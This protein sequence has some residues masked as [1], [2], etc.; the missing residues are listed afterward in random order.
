MTGK[1]LSPS[2]LLTNASLVF[3][4]ALTTSYTLISVPPDALD[5]LDQHGLLWLVGKIVGTAYS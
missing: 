1:E 4:S 5:G 3:N 2:P